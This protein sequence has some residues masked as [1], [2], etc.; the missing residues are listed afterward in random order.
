MNCT[1][2]P[3]REAAGVCTYCGKFYCADCLVDVKG[4]NYC[5]EHV[6]QAMNNT[7]TQQPNY[8]YNNSYNNNNSNAYNG[9]GIT[10][11][12]KSRLLAL[13]LCFYVG[14]LGIHRFYVGKIGTGILYLVT[15]GLFGIGTLVDFILIACGAFRDAFGLEIKNWE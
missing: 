15:F 13:L 2:H 5:R 12:T 6:T 3:E 14:V 4:R 1:L 11:S 7:Q 10:I 9:Y 8:T